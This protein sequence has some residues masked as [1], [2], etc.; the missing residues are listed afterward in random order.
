MYSMCFY[1]ICQ[2]FLMY[3]NSF[4]KEIFKQ[5]Y[6]LSTGSFGDVSFVRIVRRKVVLCTILT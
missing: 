6:I 2:H 1:H 3:D 5:K 4:R